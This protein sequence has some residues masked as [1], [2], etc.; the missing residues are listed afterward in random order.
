ML[1]PRG[2]TFQD[3]ELA[4]KEF[5][6][7]FKSKTGNSWDDRDSFVPKSGKY[8]LVE[9][10]L[11][12]STAG[13]TCSQ[14]AS[15]SSFPLTSAGCTLA[16]PIQ[17][18]IDLIFD[19][20]MFNE[21]LENFNI[22]VQKMPLGQLSQEQVQRGVDVLQQLE[23][24]LKSS[25]TQSASSVQLELQT[26]S[27]RFY[28]VIPHSFGRKRPPAIDSEAK[29]REKYDMCDV[30]SSECSSHVSGTRLTTSCVPKQ[31]GLDGY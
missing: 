7:R 31:K 30:S 19:E 25:S 13:A 21:A 27:S 29:L 12:G 9:V 16:Q 26:L 20:Q 10:E 2:K 11:E 17:D 18:L 14:V 6:A 5:H 28:Q 24:V 15:R 22:D 4:V 3:L 8:E 23:E 1:S